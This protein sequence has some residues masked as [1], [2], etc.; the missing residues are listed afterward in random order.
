MR[1]SETLDIQL[2][3]DLTQAF[4][5]SGDEEEVGSLIE[6]CLP[7]LNWE[8]SKDVLGNIR[9]S[10]KGKRQVPQKIMIC[11][12]MDEIGIIVTHIDQKGFI[13]FAPIGGI[14]IT[15]C[16]YRRVKFQ[17]GTVGVIAKEKDN[18]KERNSHSKTDKY[19]IDLGFSSQD[20]VEENVG[21]GD[22]AVFV[23]D[24]Q[25]CGD[26]YIAKA[27]DN[28]VGCFIAL[29]VLKQLKTDHE[30]IFVFS[31]Q[32]EVGARGA[33]VA[34]YSL[35]PDLAINIDTTTAGDIPGNK[36]T[37]I[38]LNKGVCIKVIDR[39]IIVSPT[40]KN[41]I[42]ETAEN[43]GIKY[44]WEVLE[45]GGTDSGPIQTT[46]GGILTGALS[47]PVKYLH[48][49]SE[50]IAI[51]DVELAVDLLLELINDAGTILESSQDTI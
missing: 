40:V 26:R 50:M 20:Q 29:E 12:H 39:S 47:I 38:S 4:G 10:K 3:R 8:I 33:K 23:G 32:E 37:A 13:R 46:K 35:D 1:K 2:L 28:R 15:D 25:Q 9:V 21:V 24:F 6:S 48:S 11:T 17:N 27:F 36:E 34:A 5:P 19:Y 31:A 41:W 42:A 49:P 16:L 22:K 18:E 14:R 45:K 43:C 30:M 44:Q 51:Q 7:D